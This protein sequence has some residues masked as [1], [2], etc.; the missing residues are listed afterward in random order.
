MRK[1]KASEL[2]G[3]L[4]VNGIID[5]NAATYALRRKQL[6]G[7]AGNFTQNSTVK[8]S[9]GPLGFQAKLAAAYLSFTTLPVG[10]TLTV[11]IV[12]YDATGNAEVILTDALDAE[13]GTV[14]EGKPFVLATTNR[15]LNADDTIEIH[16]IASD[17]V[18]G[19]QQV[20]GMVSMLF[21][22]VDPGVIDQ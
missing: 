14:R 9:L 7:S 22:P 4:G 8:T 21:D 17:D 10:G 2:G 5:V 19:T 11:R 20:G 3:A 12:A 13:V 1:T 15:V 16:T 18:V 6:R